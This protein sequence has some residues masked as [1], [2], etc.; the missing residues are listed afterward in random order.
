[1]QSTVLLLDQASYIVLAPY[2]SS[3]NLFSNHPSV[4]MLAHKQ[5]NAHSDILCLIMISV[6][7]MGYI[8]VDI[9]GFH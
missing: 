6:H 1:M 9:V 8:L 5:S 2:M 4:V 3:Q 7:S